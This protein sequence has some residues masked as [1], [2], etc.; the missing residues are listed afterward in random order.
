M[1]TLAEPRLPLRPTD[2]IVTLPIIVIIPVRNEARNLPRCL[3]SLRGVGEVYVVDSNSSDE[4]AEIARSFDATVV[5]FTYRGGWPQ[6][7]QWAMESLPLSYHLS[8]LVDS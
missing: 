5:Q 4:T 1:R 6:K 8:L 2:S 3:E 7:R